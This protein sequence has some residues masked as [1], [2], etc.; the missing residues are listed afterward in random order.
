MCGCESWTIN[1]AEHQRTDA[2]ELWCW[3]RFL[4]VPWTARRSNQSIIK[5]ID[6]E[7][8]LKGFMLKLKLKFFGYLMQRT[9]SFENTLM[10]GKIEAG[11]V[12]DEDEMVGWH[13]RLDGHEFE[14]APGVG[15]GQGSLVF[16][17]LWGHMTEWMNWPH[18]LPKSSL[19]PMNFG[20][21]CHLLLITRLLC[22]RPYMTSKALSQEVLQ[23]S[24]GLGRMLI[25]REAWYQVRRLTTQS[26]SS[27]RKFM[28]VMWRDEGETQG[29][30][31]R[32][33]EKKR[34]I[35]RFPASTLLFW[36][37]RQDTRHR[38]EVT[39]CI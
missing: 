12:S 38:R 31:E 16:C 7:S 19:F 23:F 17:S 25:F 24:N 33:K 3:R 36:H 27:L 29:E 6:P 11:E 39:L 2:F 5:E 10:L 4:R 8:S 14:Q 35:E 20:R 22:K 37:F 9:N 21:P 34:E 1:K 26:Y 30:G 18:F 15:D 28:L 13:H 32:R